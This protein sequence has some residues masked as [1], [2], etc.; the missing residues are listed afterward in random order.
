MIDTDDSGQI[1]LDEFVE[2]WYPAWKARVEFAHRAE[3]ESA[4]ALA[5]SDAEKE[6]EPSGKETRS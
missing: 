3:S 5:A 4:A 2:W 6:E 1:G